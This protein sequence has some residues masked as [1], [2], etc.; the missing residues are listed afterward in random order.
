[1]EVV[2]AVLA[3]LRHLVVGQC[4]GAAEAFVTV[5]GFAETG[6]EPREIRRSE[7]F[8]DGKAQPLAQEGFGDH[9]SRAFRS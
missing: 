9:I 8:A 6:K 2:A 3:E 4:F 7:L 5:F 1:M